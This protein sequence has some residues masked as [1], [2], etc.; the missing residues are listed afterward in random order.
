M[1]LQG[2]LPDVSVVDLIQLMAASG[3]TG[4]VRFSRTR[5]D[6]SPDEAAVYFRDGVP[7]S[8]EAAGLQGE[9]AL[10]V[11]CSWD[12]GSFVYHYGATSPWENLD[13]PLDQLMERCKE[14]EEEWREVRKLFRA[15]TATV[16]L[17]D[18]LPPGLQEVRLQRED[19]G[20]LVLA[21]TGQS[22]AALM[23]EAGGG[24][25]TLRRLRKLAEY[26]VLRVESPES[27]G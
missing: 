20:L 15:L 9:L 23:E 18:V 11:L 21:S 24:L 10:E 16:R 4:V 25:A 19:W 6:G 5:Q 26:G 14:A 17:A 13:K 3:K 22:V 8:V 7:V 12:Q 2:S 1:S 27:W